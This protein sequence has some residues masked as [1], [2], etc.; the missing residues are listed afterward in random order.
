M[1]IRVVLA[2]C[3][4]LA[5]LGYALPAVEDARDDRADALARAEL[6]A[7]RDSATRFAAE[8][9]PAPEGVAGAT[10]I[11]SIRVPRA[12]D[13]A[14]GVGPRGESLA[15]KR[16]GRVRRVET[17]I[18]FAGTVWLREP[19]RHRLRLVLELMA[20]EVV[21]TVRR[22]KSGNGTTSAHVRTPRR[23]GLSV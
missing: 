12:T 9:E 4:T 19:G 17:D 20:G 7:L 1:V 23:G 5:L 3:L 14:V 13:L 8:N 2:G 16:D 18:P 22:F 21:V 10:R 15:W 11:L 6:T